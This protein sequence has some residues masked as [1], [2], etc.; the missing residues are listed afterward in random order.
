[1]QTVEIRVIWGGYG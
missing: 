1:M